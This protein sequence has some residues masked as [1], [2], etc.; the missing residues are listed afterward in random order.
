MLSKELKRCLK[1]ESRAN[2]NSNYVLA[3]AYHNIA[4][5]LAKKCKI[6]ETEFNYIFKNELVTASLMYWLAVKSSKAWKDAKDD[7]W[8]QRQEWYRDADDRA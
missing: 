5:M 7:G 3:K 1:Y 6:T 4:V 2:S 8:L